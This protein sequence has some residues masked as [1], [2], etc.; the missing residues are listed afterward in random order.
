MPNTRIHR[1]HGGLACALLPI[2]LIAQA[3]DRSTAGKDG[4]VVIYPGRPQAPGPA[5]FSHKAHDARG[6]GYPCTQCHQEASE[7]APAVTMDEIRA[8]RSCGSCHDGRTRGPGGRAAASPV[9][10]CP[11]C[12]MPAED[13]VIRLN[14]MDPVE[15]SHT[16]HLGVDQAQKAIRACGFSCSD[17][18]PVPF[19][20][21]GN[22]TIGMEVPHESGGCARCHTGKPRDDGMP[23]AFAANTRCLTCH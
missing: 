5:V 13:I 21:S 12:H 3:G 20:R 10:D 16:R 14:R 15:F 2:F 22:G 18:H 6:A 1:F 9:K 7:T 11:A 8:G 19:D 4:D 17:C 23:V